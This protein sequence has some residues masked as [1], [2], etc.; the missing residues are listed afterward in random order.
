MPPAREILLQTH[1]PE[2]MLDRLTELANEQEVGNRKLRAVTDELLAGHLLPGA[3][4]L[5]P[6]LTPELAPLLALGHGPGKPEPVVVLESPDACI[7]ALETSYAEL[8]AQFKAHTERHDSGE[9]TALVYP[10]EQLFSTPKAAL[11]EL[12]R[13]SRLLI[14]PVVLA[15]D[16]QSPSFT[17]DV[18]S[19]HAMT[20][21]LAR[22]RKRED[23][24]KPLVNRIHQARQDGQLVVMTA[25]SD[26]GRQ[27][28][29]HLLRHYG[30]GASAH[31][32]PLSAEDIEER[33]HDRSI[34]ALTLVGGA[35]PG[36]ELEA[37]HLVVIDEEEIFNTTR[38]RRIGRQRQHTNAGKLIREIAEL[39]EGDFVVHIDHG[40]G[41]F[42]QMV[43][44][45]V[46]GIE[47]D[48]LLL[49]Y[50]GDERVYV[51]VTSLGR[52]QKYHSASGKTARL[53]R[54]GNE[55]WSQ[56]KKRT[57]KAVAEVAEVLVKLYA[58]RQARDGHAFSRPDTFYRQWEATFPHIE[59]IDQQ[60]AIDEVI[61]D[62]CSPRPA[63]RL[64]CGDVGY[65]KTEV[66]I[67]AAVKVALDGKQVAILV[68][69]T[70]LAEQHRL[71]FK[72]RCRGLPIEIDSL[73]RFR[74]A[75]EQT[76]VIKRLDDGTLDI[77]IGTHR[78]LSKDISFRDLGL[79]VI[80]EEHRFGVRH[81]EQ[82]AKWRSTI[83]CIV[84]SA[85]PIPRTLQM[86]T[87][88]L[89]DL[90]LITTPPENRKAVRT[91]VCRGAQPLITEAIGRELARG[92]QVFY[93]RNRVG[94]LAEIAQRLAE[95]CP[96]ARPVVAHGQMAETALE[97]AMLGFMAGQYNILVA[98]SIIESGLD[99]PN[100][101]TMFI[102]RADTF[103]LAQLYQL[104]GRVGRS[105]ERAYCYLM[106][107][108]RKKLTGDGAKRVAILERFSEL[109]S[110]IHI[111]THDLEIRGAGNILGEVQS[112]H[113]AEV[114]Y[115]LYIRMLDEAVREL[116]H[117]DLGA[118]V[119]PTVKIATSAYLPDTYIP[120]SSQRLMTYK[121]LAAVRTEQELADAVD[122]LV[123]RFGRMPVE[124]LRLIDSLE[125][126]VL[127][128][129]LGLAQVEQGP[130]AVVLTLH[131]KGRLQ[132]ETLLP[133][134]N[135][136]GALFRLTP[137]MLLMRTLKRDEQIDPVATTKAILRQLHGLANSAN[138]VV[139]D[140]S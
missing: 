85:T 78:L 11:A 48:F 26:G 131:P 111:A 68:P 18:G 44:L 89:R 50:R 116:R 67:R 39:N 36:F 132:V 138:T 98:T 112:G 2:R 14:R 32:G 139:V 42:I 124:A 80:D 55:R 94:E 31:D 81:K 103:G 41:R 123:D 101:N 27:R 96:G 52:V 5:L 102:E 16:D 83:H 1:A 126:R 77:V 4:A 3:E 9:D 113:I 122:N 87:L 118:P 65:G 107:P 21:A 20:A 110:G 79:L 109:S 10:P 91:I 75:K 93:I 84:L 15:E 100:A 104:R 99:I 64:V 57:R 49:L 97:Q 95:L 128:I 86:A 63:W 115:D 19:N 133:L 61:E 88:G 136:R 33:R 59:T 40:V 74:S 22:D 45:T 92:G 47:Q 137:G 129:D 66:A 125:I 119:D 108:H 127:A 37:F 13:Y 105:S 23:G 120:D 24:L 117:E 130:A 71:T 54:L 53:D 106:V 28:L 51:P 140:A 6:A 8:T 34:D 82:M 135:A 38:S 29:E 134:V 17:L 43:R 25:R 70:V 73:S 30:V 58:E 114:G 62:L 76:D 72:E 60:R 46:G 35:G 12:E 90:S 56:A 69:T 7:A 121:R